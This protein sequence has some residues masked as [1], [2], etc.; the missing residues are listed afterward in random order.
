MATIVRW[1]P[2]REV[3]TI[4]N[5][6]ERWLD[7]VRN[8][9]VSNQNEITRSLAVNIYE[10]NDAYTVVT[11]LAGVNPDAIEI[12]L[13]ENVLTIAGEASEPEVDE[14]TRVH[15]QERRFGK[16]SRSLT[17]P[18]TVDADAVNAD[19]ENGVLTLTLPK[20]PNAQPRAIPVTVRN[21]N[22]N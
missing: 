19:F 5:V 15:V 13:H 1:N 14:N 9:T 12:N 20:S 10:T 18:N 8:H 6:V 4:N 11:A 16:F 22:N 21:V 7:E 2:I 17:L 3:P